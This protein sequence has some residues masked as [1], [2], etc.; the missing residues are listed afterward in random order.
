[1]K[2][3]IKQSLNTKDIKILSKKLTVYAEQILECDRIIKDT[4]IHKDLCMQKLKDAMGNYTNGRVSNF[5]LER[6]FV[7]L[8]ASPL[9][10]TP[11][12]EVRS[13]RKSS[14]KIKKI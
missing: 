8:K 1:M 9:P 10:F 7:P 5:L 13:E 2:S 3:S 4:K 6:D 14:I 12:K 11:A